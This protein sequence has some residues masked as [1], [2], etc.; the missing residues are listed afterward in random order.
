MFPRANGLKSYDGRLSGL[1]S[2]TGYIGTE[3]TTKGETTI[4]RLVRVDEIKRELDA[5]RPK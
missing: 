4:R 5:L 1:K 2:R 3:P